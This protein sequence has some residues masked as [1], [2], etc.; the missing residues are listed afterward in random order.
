[1]LQDLLALVKELQARLVR[2]CG[3]STEQ[4]EV[5]SEIAGGKLHTHIFCETSAP[6]LFFSY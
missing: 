2:D 3:L 5:S 6:F 1:M 4:L